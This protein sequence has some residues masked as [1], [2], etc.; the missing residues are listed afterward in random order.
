MSK[1]D[2]DNLATMATDLQ[3]EVD[4]LKAE[5]ALAR[6]IVC[7]PLEQTEAEVKALEPGNTPM[8]CRLIDLANLK[9][10]NEAGARQNRELRDSLARL[11]AENASLREQGRAVEGERDQH[12]ELSVKWRRFAEQA[13]RERDAAVAQRDALDES[14]TAV[15]N[16]AA[17]RQSLAR[18]T[19]PMPKREEARCPS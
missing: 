19:V 4:R 9:S 6:R 5:V 1:R 17:S 15:A 18:A 7:Q 14:L 10:S 13:R 16:Y 3:A 2:T 8:A 12:Y 11:A